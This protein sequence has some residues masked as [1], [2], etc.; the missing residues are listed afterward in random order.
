MKE[1]VTK[2][3]FENISNKDK[4]NINFQLDNISPEKTL[5]DQFETAGT[6]SLSYSNNWFNSSLKTNSS[7]ICGSIDQDET[8]LKKTTYIDNEDI[9]LHSST[10][11]KKKTV[12]ERTKINSSENSLTRKTITSNQDSDDNSTDN[13][14]MEQPVHNNPE[15]NVNPILNNEMALPNSQQVPLRNALEAVSLIDGSNIPLSHF[16]EGCYEAK[17]MPPTPAAQENLAQL[18]RS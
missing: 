3:N 1:K 18:L 4:T 13:K 8:F 5:M 11:I 10:I 16:I 14:Q 9:S 17:A 7:I 6:S 12:E 15:E 2:D